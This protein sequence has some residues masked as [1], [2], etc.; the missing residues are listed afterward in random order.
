MGLPAHKAHA[1]AGGIEGGNCTDTSFGS[2]MGCFGNCATAT[3]A[4][5]GGPD[6]FAR[7]PVFGDAAR[8]IRLDGSSVRQQQ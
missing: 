4:I 5:T 3:P 8:L 7:G 1:G 2:P 6:T